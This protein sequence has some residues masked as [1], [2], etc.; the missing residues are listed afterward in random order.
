MDDLWPDALTASEGMVK[1][2]CYGGRR[3][4]IRTSRAAQISRSVARHAQLRLSTRTD[5]VKPSRCAPNQRA[6]AF[7]MR[8]QVSGVAGNIVLVMRRPDTPNRAASRHRL[9]KL[10]RTA[11]IARAAMSCQYTAHPPLRQVQAQ[12][13]LSLFLLQMS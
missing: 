2:D 12:A 5:H 4:A 10:S 1:S 13:L 9:T 7:C 11:L 3:I 6:P 8:H